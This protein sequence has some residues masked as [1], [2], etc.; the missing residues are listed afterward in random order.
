MPQCCTAR[1]APDQD[2]LIAVEPAGSACAVSHVAAELAV[3]VR[4]GGRLG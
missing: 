2:L 4:F 3:E 1:L